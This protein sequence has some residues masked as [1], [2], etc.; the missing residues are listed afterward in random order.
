VYITESDHSME[1]QF[2]GL[3]LDDQFVCEPWEIIFKNICIIYGPKDCLEATVNC[4]V[5]ASGLKMKY[6]SLSRGLSKMLVSKGKQGIH[7]KDVL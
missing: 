1:I 6:S 7:S 2:V 4:M 5:T 3:Q